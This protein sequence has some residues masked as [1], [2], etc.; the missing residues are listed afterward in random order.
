VKASRIQLPNLVAYEIPTKTELLL[1]YLNPFNPETWIPY[2]LANDSFV[3]LTI[4]DATGAVVRTLLVGHKP[5]AAYESK[6][7]TI[8]RDGRNN[9]G[10]RVASGVYFY[11]L[12]ANDFTAT[13]K[14]II[15][16]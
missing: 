1:N 16:K 3:K 11:T 7:K 5:A 4:Y 13:R 2:R 14:M 8:Y 9:W 10:E 12:T 15:L 6:G